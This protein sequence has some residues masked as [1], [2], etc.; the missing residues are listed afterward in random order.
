MDDEGQVLGFLF[1]FIT[2]KVK[3]GFEGILPEW[4]QIQSS[5][6]LNSS[7]E[8]FAG[9]FREFSP[10]NYPIARELAASWTNIDESLLYLFGGRIKHRN[11]SYY[12]LNALWVFNISPLEW[13]W[14][15]GIQWFNSGFGFPD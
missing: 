4:R 5:R 13:A 14:F 9:N 1:L 7:F 11:G 6:S 15:H 10:A 12:F 8:G 3:R 2:P